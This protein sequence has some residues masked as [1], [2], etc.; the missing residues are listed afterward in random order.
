MLSL[1]F[2][3]LL[4]GLVFLLVSPFED[5]L[6]ATSVKGSG[7]FSGFYTPDLIH[8]SEDY[9]G[10]WLLGNDITSACTYTYFIDLIH[11]HMFFYVHVP[12]HIFMQVKI[13]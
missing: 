7:E 9:A 4:L 8:T 13:I 10:A 12:A 5:G 2:S 1:F 11:S 6:Q 3:V